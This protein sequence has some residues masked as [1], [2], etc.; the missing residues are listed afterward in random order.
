MPVKKPHAHKAN[1]YND[2]ALKLASEIFGVEHLHYGYFAKIKPSVENLPRAQEA[3]VARLLSYIPKKG[4]KRI[5]DVGCG[6]GGVAAQLVKRGYNVICLAPDPYLIAKTRERTGDR[7]ETITDLYENV[8]D[9]VADGA[10]DLLLMSESCQYIKIEPG[11]ENHRR[12][13]RP[14]GYILVGDF[15]RTKPADA[16][17]PSKSGHMLAEFLDAAH[18]NGFKLIKQEDITRAVA[19]TMDLYQDFISNRVFPVLAAVLEVVRRAAPLVYKALRFFFEKKALKLKDE[20]ERQGA[21]LFKEYK[22][23]MIFLFQRVS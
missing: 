17:N 4:V 12:F 22:R 18:R 13:I 6:S 19:P 10:I 14:G 1:Y 20:Y 23:Y 3:Y 11:F 21:D 9:Q 7:V 15:F 16:R 5:F 8:E 2:I